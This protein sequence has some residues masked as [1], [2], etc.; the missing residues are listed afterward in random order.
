M[1]KTSAQRSEE[2]IVKSL[3]VNRRRPSHFFQ[4]SDKKFEQ[5]RVDPSLQE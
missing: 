1:A 3:Q 2:G 5:D 4:A